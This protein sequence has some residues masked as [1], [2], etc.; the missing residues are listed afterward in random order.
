MQSSHAA[1]AVSSVFDEDNL[2]ADAG[3]VPVVRL[4]ERAGLPGL[5]E[6]A[7]RISGSVNGG[8]ANPAAK[9][10]S[11]VAAMCAGADSIDDA[12][13]LR[14]GAVATAFGGVRA[15]STLGTFLRSF[16][17]GHTLQLHA[18]HRRLLGEL[19]G[20]A[21]L[22]PGADQVAF[23]TNDIAEVDQHIAVNAAIDNRLRQLPVVP[24][25]VSLRQHAP[26]VGLH[27]LHHRRCAGA[28][29]LAVDRVFPC[30]G[31]RACARCRAARP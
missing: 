9:V 12:D 15:P 14:H 24:R 1:A 6:S 8:G 11:L 25:P 20:R 23:T 13:R 27:R 3:L 5:V 2:I 31:A 29:L 28:A 4:A 30:Q 18:V 19:A 26:R 17:H 10:M 22:L 7:V 16:T 21:P